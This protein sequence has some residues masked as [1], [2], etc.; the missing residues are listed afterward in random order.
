MKAVTLHQ[1]WA[2][3]IALGVKTIETRSWSTAYRGP[4]AIHAG[5]SESALHYL[6]WME[7]HQG[8]AEPTLEPFAD[9]ITMVHSHRRGVIKAHHDLP[10][11]AIVATCTL[12]DVVPIIAHDSEEAEATWPPERRVCVLR[13]PG[14][15]CGQ[16]DALIVGGGQPKLIVPNQEP[17]GDFTPGRYA[18]LLEDVK[19]TTERCPA[20]W[21]NGADDARANDCDPR[22][23]GRHEDGAG[24]ALCPRGP[25]PCSTCDGTGRCDPVST[26]GRQGLWT[27]TP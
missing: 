22:C 2:S 14:K 27:W 11:G 5:R 4:L 18:W 21:G 9:R 23:D 17:Y 15:W 6:G 24:R 1:P 13:T 7:E 3:L 26:R 8:E 20:C 16:A 10:L 25:E 19:P 12:A